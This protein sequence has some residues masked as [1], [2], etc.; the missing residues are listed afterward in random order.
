MNGTYFLR[1]K[2]CIDMGLSLRQR[3]QTRSVGN[4]AAFQLP[5]PC[6]GVRI[7]RSERLM[8]INKESSTN[9][10]RKPRMIE[11]DGWENNPARFKYFT[12]TGDRPPLMYI[13]TYY[14]GD[15]TSFLICVFPARNTC[16]SIL[17]HR[18]MDRVITNI[19]MKPPKEI[20]KWCLSYGVI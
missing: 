3:R 19:G 1:S 2:S 14:I 7:L 4:V 10:T 6:Q 18:H 20:L 12:Y 8:R 17:F 15:R 9:Q 11:D 5:I 16:R 13:F